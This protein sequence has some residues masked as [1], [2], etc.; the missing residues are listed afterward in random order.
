MYTCSYCNEI[1]H[2]INKCKHSD[3]E[4][5][6]EKIKKDAVIHYYCMLKY[7]FNFLLYSLKLLT[8]PELRIISYK[9]K[10]DNKLSYKPNKLELQKYLYF[11]VEY[12]SFENKESITIPYF[13]NNILW[14]YATVINRLI[15]KKEVILVYM[16]IIKISPRP[17]VYNIDLELVNS[18]DDN[19]MNNNY[20]CSIC[21]ESMIDLNICL[22]NCKHSFCSNCIKL[23]LVSL[24]RYSKD[25]NNYYPNCP[26]CRTYISK[27]L[28][29]DYDS[30]RYFSSTFIE[31]FTPGYFNSI[32]E[33]SIM[34]VHNYENKFYYSEN[35]EDNIEEEEF[36]PYNARI[37][38]PRNI[39][40]FTYLQNIIIN[41]ITI[42]M[43][44]TSIIQYWFFFIGTIYILHH[45][46][47]HDI[48]QPVCD[49]EEIIY[50]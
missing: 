45:F 39:L 11:L 18:I 23:Y 48:E 21:L 49:L 38:L 13:D 41:N 22:I 44:M 33:S 19:E 42:I 30:Y 36:S 29:N 7:D 27:I 28:I 35:D 3:I 1:G 24:Y 5:L 14:D 6:Q 12:F 10:L 16:D 25:Y 40:L 20:K 34:K 43:N 2:S 26:L 4:I 9:N 17:F 8:I 31:Y 15:H 47:K 46:S 32:S 50:I 37:H